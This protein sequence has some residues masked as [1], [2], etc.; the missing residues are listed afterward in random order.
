[1]LSSTAYISQASGDHLESM[2]MS[3]QNVYVQTI[4]TRATA[5]AME[6]THTKYIFSSTWRHNMNT[7]C[8]YLA[9]FH[10]HPMHTSPALWLDLEADAVL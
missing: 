7:Y 10:P 1:M 9:L 3:N 4:P 2:M 6:S 8:N 5:W